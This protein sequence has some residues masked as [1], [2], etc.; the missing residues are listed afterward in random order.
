MLCTFDTHD[1]CNDR[2]VIQYDV[3]TYPH[4]WFTFLACLGDLQI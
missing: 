2:S 4:I 1:I 3:C